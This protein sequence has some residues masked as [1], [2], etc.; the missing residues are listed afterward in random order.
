MFTIAPT[1]IAQFAPTVIALAAPIAV[2]MPELVAKLYAT[3]YSPAAS[4]PPVPIVSVGAARY[5][6]AKA[7]VV[8]WPDGDET[9]PAAAT[10]RVGSNTAR[11]DPTIAERYAPP[12]CASIV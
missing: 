6:V 1:L 3:R 2:S 8:S 10:A 7:N 5:P 12:A 4:V 9:R 11:V